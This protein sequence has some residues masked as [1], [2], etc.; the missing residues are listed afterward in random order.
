M[1][2]CR[3]LL[4]REEWMKIMYAAYL[5]QLFQNRLVNTALLEINPRRRDH[6]VNYLLVDAAD[7]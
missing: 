3:H 7:L 4:E 1:V 6:I 5:S 2:K